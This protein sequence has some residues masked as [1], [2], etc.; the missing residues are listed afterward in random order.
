MSTEKMK[1]LRI[2]YKDDPQMRVNLDLLLLARIGKD[3]LLRFWEDN[4]L[5]QNQQQ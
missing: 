1:E 2:E 4:N 5:N 3:A